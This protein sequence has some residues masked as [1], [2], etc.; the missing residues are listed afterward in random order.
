MIFNHH[1]HPMSP[2]KLL[3][4]YS[5]CESRT[6]S[7]STTAP[8][9]SSRDAYSLPS[10]AFFPM[11][12]CGVLPSQAP[13]SLPAINA[14]RHPALIGGSNSK[15]SLACRSV[16]AIY[17]N[18]ASITTIRGPDQPCLYPRV[19]PVRLTPRKK[20]CRHCPRRKVATRHCSYATEVCQMDCDT[21][22]Y[23][24]SGG[25]A[26][27]SGVRARVLRVPVALT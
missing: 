14:C 6:L 15:R 24:M 12:A 8:I 10:A 25:P 23:K 16:V 7:P 4:F 19:L 3:V 26:D 18:P 17:V 21:A 13:G 11:P 27:T 1:L 5:Q 9:A 20:R 2:A 22:A